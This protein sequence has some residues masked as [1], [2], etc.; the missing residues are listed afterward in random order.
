VHMAPDVQFG[1][2]D[3]VAGALGA[4]GVGMIL[5]HAAL[6]L[7]SSRKAGL[8]SRKFLAGG[9]LEYLALLSI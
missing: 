5:T 4:V 9:L 1:S 3:V 2:I 6:S 7:A 8:H